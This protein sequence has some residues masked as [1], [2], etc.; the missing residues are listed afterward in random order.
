MWQVQRDILT[1]KFDGPTPKPVSRGARNPLV[2]AYRTKDGRYVQFTVLRPDPYWKDFCEAIDMPQLVDDPR[3]ATMADRQV[4]GDACVAILDEKFAAK[5]LDEWCSALERF[6]GAWAPMQVPYDLLSDPNA[7]AN[8]Y[9]TEVD[10]GLDE[11]IEVV[12]SPVTFDEYDQPR[13]MP[14]APEVGQHTEEILLEL[15][16]TWDEIGALKDA[17]VIT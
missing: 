11:P 7:R 8:G 6:P 1:A 13:R 15:G 3:F 14:G 9:F 2:G 5:T 16:H 10:V 17:S 12:S 4:N